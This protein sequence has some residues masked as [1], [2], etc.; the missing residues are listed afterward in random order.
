MNAGEYTDAQRHI[1]AQNGTRSTYL[2]PMP[3][4][5]CGENQLNAQRS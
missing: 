1:A 2:P 3:E 4:Q 5:R